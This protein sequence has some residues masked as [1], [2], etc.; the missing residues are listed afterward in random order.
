MADVIV[1]LRIMPKDV[2]VNLDNLEEK[3]KNLIRPQRMQ[4]EPIAFG[5]IALKIIKLIPDAEGELEKI[6]KKIKSLSEVG[7]VEVVNI[8]RSL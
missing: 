4:R 8:T 5:L 3:I 6:E 2:E 1:T 7:N